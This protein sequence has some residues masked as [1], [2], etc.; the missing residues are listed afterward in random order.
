MGRRRA[1]HLLVVHWRGFGAIACAAFAALVSAAIQPRQ[2]AWA[3]G[4]Q[5]CDA[6]VFSSS[7]A[8]R[9]VVRARAPWA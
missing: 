1:A 3:G 6:H 4:L 5:R 9:W 2:R 7:G 8:G